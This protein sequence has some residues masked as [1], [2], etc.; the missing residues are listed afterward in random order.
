MNHVFFIFLEDPMQNKFC[1]L[2]I[3]TICAAL[4][5]LFSSVN[6]F[7]LIEGR[8]RYGFLASTPTYSDLYSASSTPSATPTQG[9]GLEV[10]VSPP[11]FPVGVGL[12]YEDFEN[13]VSSG[14][15]SYDLTWDKTSLVINY[16]I[17][18]TLIFL[19]PI[20]SIGLSQNNNYKVVVSGNQVANYSA[21]NAEMYSLGFEGGAHILG[22][23]LGGEIGYQKYKLKGATD[24][25]GGQGSTDID[26]SGTYISLLAGFSF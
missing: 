2:N 12:R 7:A 13:K 11:L 1:F 14:N 20:A 4:F 16:R 3:K 18:D 5:S 10:I 22:L 15:T 23:L 21:N 26:L 9:Y 6:S 8:L 17:I 19:G 25:T 24:T